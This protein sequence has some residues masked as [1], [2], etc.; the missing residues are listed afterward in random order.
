[1]SFLKK[2]NRLVSD[3]RNQ[4]TLNESVCFLKD[5]KGYRDPGGTNATG[6]PNW[7]PRNLNTLEG[8]SSFVAGTFAGQDQ[9]NTTFDVFP[10]RYEVVWHAPFFRAGY[11]TTR[12][13]DTTNSVT[14][15]VSTPGNQHPTYGGTTLVE[16]MVIF[17]LNTTVTLRLEYT[18]DTAV[19]NDGLGL[20]QY[21]DSALPSIYTTVK[22]RKL[23]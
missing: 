16:G 23:K 4:K 12:L 8:D 22:I 3:M 5:V 2:L 11:C 1:M 15:G 13:R 7:Q 9:T 14:L 18:T 21:Y 10:G 6:S 20:Y 17:T 19:T